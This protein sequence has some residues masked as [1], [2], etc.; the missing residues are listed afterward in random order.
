MGHEKGRV[1]PGRARA[2]MLMLFARA[3]EK[4]AA[5]NARR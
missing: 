1:F 3:K 4:A 2:K 5:M